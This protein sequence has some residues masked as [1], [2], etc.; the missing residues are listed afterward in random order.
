MKIDS[1]GEE[2]ADVKGHMACWIKI[3]TKATSGWVRGQTSPVSE[4]EGPKLYNN[5]NNNI[6]ALFP[7]KL[8]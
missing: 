3:H 2:E 5:N 7:S 4:D 1:G 6:K 8:G